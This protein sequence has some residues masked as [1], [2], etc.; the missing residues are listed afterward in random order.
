MHRDPR[1]GGRQLE[2]GGRDAEEQARSAHERVPRGHAGHASGPSLDDRDPVPAA[3]HQIPSVVGPGHLAYRD[4]A[5]HG[6]DDLVSGGLAGGHAVDGH[7]VRQSTGRVDLQAVPKHGQPDP[8]RGDGV[9]PVGHGVDHRL[10]DRFRAVLRHIDPHRRLAR[11]NTHVAHH[12]MH[13]FGDL[14]L[15]GP[16]DLLCVQLGGGA[17]LAPI[18]RGHDHRVPQPL[19]R[20]PRTQQH[21]RHG[22]PE[23]TV[24]VLR[25]QAEPR[26]ASA[27]IRSP[28]H[29]QQ[30]L[31]ETLAECLIP[32]SQDDLL[33]EPQVAGLASPPRQPELLIGRHPALGAAYANEAPAGATMVRIPFGHVHRQHRA[34]IRQPHVM[35]LYRHR[36]FDGVRA[37]LRQH[38]VQGRKLTPRQALH[39]PVVGHAAKHRP[40]P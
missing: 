5:E 12:E 18:V 17:I 6:R 27:R 34:P 32:R 38:V 35:R 36:R 15:Q 31:P 28:R 11:G 4:A 25:E 8:L 22:G 30:R 9:V 3:L 39:S 16:T 37:Y 14:A 21:A 20:L 24:L 10:E 23:H 26:Q 2:T 19:L 33:V 7:V 13:R 1:P 29:A 40:A